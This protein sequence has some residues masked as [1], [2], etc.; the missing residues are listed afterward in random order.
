MIG[1]VAVVLGPSGS[2]SF[3]DAGNHGWPP[4]R[5]AGRPVV[6]VSR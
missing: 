5:P 4:G 2:M 1:I 6:V 3:E